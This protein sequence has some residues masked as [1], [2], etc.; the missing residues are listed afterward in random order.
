MTFLINIPRPITIMAMN[1]LAKVD[2][3]I[4]TRVSDGV[5]ETV[6]WSYNN[7]QAWLAQIAIDLLQF[8]D[9][10][11]SLLIS[12]VVWIVHNTI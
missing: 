9:N 4:A 7:D 6:K 10:F 12:I 8:F 3:N 2:Y 11:G 1:E 5:A